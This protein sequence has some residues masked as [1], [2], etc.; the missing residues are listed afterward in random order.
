MPACVFVGY[1]RVANV[2][3]RK[4]LTRKNMAT[5]LRLSYEEF[6][7]R[8]DWENLHGEEAASTGGVAH[9]RRLAEALLQD[10]LGRYER[11]V[12]VGNAVASA[13]QCA[14]RPFNDWAPLTSGD[15]LTVARVPHTSQRNWT[16]HTRW[17]QGAGPWAIQSRD[18]MNELRAS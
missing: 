1:D 11:A 18:F 12:F 2:A 7:G 16:A 17:G 6:C 8:F 9:D 10:K 13:F 14:D 3:N 5:L 4:A 15:A